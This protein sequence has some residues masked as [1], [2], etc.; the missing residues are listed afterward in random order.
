MHGQE[1]LTKDEIINPKQ[2]DI[3]IINKCGT[4][5][6]IAAAK[7]L[8]KLILDHRL[9]QTFRLRKFT[10]KIKENS[11]INANFR[12]RRCYQKPDGSTLSALVGVMSRNQS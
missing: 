10:M 8:M 4:E 12:T 6:N 5:E 7:N 11:K 3:D 2:E 1:K 9:H